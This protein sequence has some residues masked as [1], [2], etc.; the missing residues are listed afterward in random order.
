[1]HTDHRLLALLKPVKG[2]FTLTVLASV[3]SG[4][5]T[6]AMAWF[7]TAVINGAFLE[8]R[9]LLD[10]QP[11]LVWL[12]ILTVLKSL[13]VWANRS[14]GKLTTTR[15]KSILRDKVLTHLTQL[16]PQYVK[17]QRTGELTQTLSD[18]IEKLDPWFGDYLPQLI[19]AVVIPLIILVIV[20]PLDLLSGI[21]FPGIENP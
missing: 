7:L 21:V 19:V 18:G 16:G 10:M 5:L 15:I 8:H 4:G 17:G 2:W 6:V 12:V 14:F 1:M 11:D 9:T 3:F 20:F 13:M